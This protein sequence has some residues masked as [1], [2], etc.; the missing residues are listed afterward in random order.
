MLH[1]IAWIASVPVSLF[2]R[3]RQVR[4][5][6]P[7]VVGSQLSLFSFLRAV[8]FVTSMCLIASVYIFGNERVFKMKIFELSHQYA[9]EQIHIIF[10]ILTGIRQV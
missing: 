2:S 10:F 8:V 3:K 6:S 4:F 7:R 9:G 5:L 1:R